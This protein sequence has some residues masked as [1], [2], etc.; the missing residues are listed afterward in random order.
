MSRALRRKPQAPCG[1]KFPQRRAREKS[2]LALLIAS[3]KANG[4]VK[5]QSRVNIKGRKIS[6]Q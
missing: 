1:S 5:S 6:P 4:A 2:N 3:G